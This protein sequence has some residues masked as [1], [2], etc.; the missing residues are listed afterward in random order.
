MR[1][2]GPNPSPAGPSKAAL[3]LETALV[4]AITTAGGRFVVPAQDYL[5]SNHTVVLDGARDY[6][7]EF[8][9]GTTLRF[10]YGYGVRFTNSHNVSIIGNGVALDAESKNYAQGVVRAIAADSVDVSIDAG[11]LQPDQ[12]YPPFSAAGGLAGAKAAFWDAHTR[13][14]HNYGNQFLNHSTQLPTGGEWR[15]NFK[16]PPHDAAVGDLFT[17]FPRRGETWHLL[18]CS[19]V[20]TRNVSI[21]AGGNMGFLEQHGGGGHVY[22][23]VKI[24]RRAG[25]S[26]L[27]A[28]NADG[29]HSSDVGVGPALLDSEISFTG[30]DFLNIH[31]RMNV[32]CDA[33]GPDGLLLTDVTG[34][35]TL[36]PLRARHSLAFYRLNTLAHIATA[37]VASSA[38]VTDAATLA[39]CA[40][41]WA[42]MQ[43]PPYSA[44]IIINQWPKT[45][46]F[47][48]RFTEQLPTAVGSPRYNLA[49][50]E[51]RSAAGAVVRRTHFHDGFSRMGLLKAINLTYEHN[52]VERAHGLH[53]YSEQ[54]W[55]E[56]DL[57]IRNVTLRNNTIVFGSEPT[58]TPHV[59]VMAGLQDIR[60]F[61]TS[62]MLGNGTRVERADGC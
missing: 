40:D 22:E 6:E 1:W 49:N 10:F 53:I 12:R 14:M 38:R 13:R 4:A 2:T 47:A 15:L 50:F 41:A 48:V 32:I 26:D 56:G 11:F 7:I 30:D 3:A 9:P 25:S 51:Q 59:D 46:V 34:G 19:R 52:L 23:R 39:R 24:V 55:L 43:Q 18:N 33:D 44:R 54:E 61:D 5:F 20:T 42:E 60:C 58:Q 31:N 37:T 8:E 17:V 27:M 16:G 57:G 21:Y 35:L 36:A 62:F 28:L 45:G 29:F